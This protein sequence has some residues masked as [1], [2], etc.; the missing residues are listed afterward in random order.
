MLHLPAIKQALL[1]TALDWGARLQHPQSGSAYQRAILRAMG[2]R[3]AGPVAFAPGASFLAPQNLSLGR[4][5]T[6]GAFTR[7]V[8]WAPV[9]IGDDFMASDSLTINSGNHDPVSLS[10]RLGPIKIG[11]RVWCGINVQICA[12]VEIG[13]DVVIGA[14]S[15]VLR[16]L[17]PN[18][19]AAGTP[20]KPLRSLDR[21]PGAP[22]WSMWQERSGFNAPETRRWRRFLKQLRTWA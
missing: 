8:S 6:F 20:A 2:V 14:G 13:D 17:P 4:Y 21:P 22:L 19:I 12:G 9:E 7:I 15:V 5:V 18:C 10:P 11:S 1:E 3:V 16:S